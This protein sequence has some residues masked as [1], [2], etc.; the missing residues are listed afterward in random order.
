LRVAETFCYA[1]VESKGLFCTP[2]TNLASFV[3]DCGLQQHF[4][5]VVEENQDGM[6]TSAV[7]GAIEVLDGQ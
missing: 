4:K 2:L 1:G 5:S 3:Q 7:E 6:H